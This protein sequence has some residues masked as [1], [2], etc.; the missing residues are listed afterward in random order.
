MNEKTVTP[1]TDDCLLLSRLLERT[2]SASAWLRA[3]IADG[4]SKSDGMTIE[5]TLVTEGYLS[6]LLEQIELNA[7]GADETAEFER[8]HVQ[9]SPYIGQM[10]LRWYVASGKNRS[11]IRVTPD[12]QCL[13]TI[14]EYELAVSD[15]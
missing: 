12:Y 2:N 7:R 8:W 3:A 10:L 4:C 9:L 13:V 15:D 11:S 1:N 6:F 14:S 5:E